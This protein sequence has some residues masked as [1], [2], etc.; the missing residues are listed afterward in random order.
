MEPQRRSIRLVADRYS[1]PGRVFSITLCVRD[2]RPVFNDGV[3]AR[4]TID[5]L[6]A[7]STMTGA[8]LYAYCLMPDHVHLLLG[9]SPAISVP[10]FVGRWKTLC[11]R[12]WL[13]RTNQASFWRR[14][15]FDHA[16]RQDEDLL[17]VGNYILMNPV[18]AGLVERPDDYGLSGSLEWDLG[19]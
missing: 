2:R 16:L 12:E 19:R 1:E 7:L 14:S 11:A 3:F 13:R 17:R 6:R 8:R 4:H 9:P 5:F 10:G 18:R 15:F